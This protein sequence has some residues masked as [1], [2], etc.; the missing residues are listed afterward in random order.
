M[1]DLFKILIIDDEEVVLDSCTMIL[2]GGNYD[3]ATASNGELGVELAQDF[4]PGL[5]FVDLKM[6]G[7]SGFEVIERINAIDPSIVVIVITG[8]ATVSS[9]VDAMKRG[10]YDFLPKPFTPDEFRLITQR[11]VEKRTLV[12]ETQA[13]RREKEALREQFAAIV[14][15]ELRS[16][17]GAIQ[18]NLFALTIDLAEKLT[19]DQK[20]RLDRMKV[21]IDD[22][23]KIISTWLR[24]I[25][26]D[27]SQIRDSF[28]PTDLN[29]VILKAVESLQIQATRKDIE[30]ITNIIESMNPVN[31][32]EVTLTEAMVNLIGNA[33]KYSRGGSKVEVQAQQ[34]GDK[35]VISVI[36]SG[37]GIAREDLPYLFD[38]F[39]IGKTGTAGERSSGIGLSVTKRI[40]EAHDG[41][42]TVESEPGKGSIFRITLPVTQADL[43]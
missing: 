29:T 31:G 8:Y 23:L 39:T 1:D 7:I 13:L 33:V 34:E 22:L 30:I 24:A 2:E 14:S 16:P 9:A 4:Q 21:R 38:S 43:I 25:S 18:Q 42:L 35:I 40:I 37:V 12:L 20:N 19:D 11:G 28:K 26:G 10:A 3:V 5:I 6:P 15:H 41:I 17:L 36:D 27:I 32:D